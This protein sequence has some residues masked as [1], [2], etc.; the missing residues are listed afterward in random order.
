MLKW[1]KAMLVMMLCL[2]CMIVSCSTLANYFLPQLSQRH[3]RVDLSGP[4]TSYRWYEPYKCG[5]LKLKTCYTEH[6]EHDFD[7]TKAD[8][9]KKFNDMGFDCAVREQPGQKAAKPE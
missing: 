3:L 7:F 4:F 6:V 1:Q 8:D 9:R 5:F 2:I